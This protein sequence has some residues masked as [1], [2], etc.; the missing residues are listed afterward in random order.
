L[1][2]TTVPIEARVTDRDIAIEILRLAFELKVGGT[3]VGQ[4]EIGPYTYLHT[5]VFARANAYHPTLRAS[6]PV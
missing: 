4:G 6:Q 5:P 1:P 3:L 2:H